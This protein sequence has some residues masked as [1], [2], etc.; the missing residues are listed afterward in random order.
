MLDGLDAIA[1]RAVLAAAIAER[2][3]RPVPRVDLVWTGPEARQADSRDTSIVVKELFELAKRS[4][5]IGGYC[6]D[7]A[8]SILGPLHTAMAER[9]VAVTMFL[10]IEGQ[11]PSVEAMTEFA[12]AKMDEFFAKRWKFGD[13]RPDV[14]YDPRTITPGPITSLHAKCIVVDDEYALVTSANFTGAGQT[15]NI[16][17]GVRIEDSRFA[18][19]LAKQWHALRESRLV[20]KY[21]G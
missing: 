5:I 14:Y 17:V 15:R 8:E 13:P 20:R 3:H 9:G 4:V 18:S 2:R 19:R 6:F 11:A 21:E 1:A 10:D 12:T 7:H 16:E